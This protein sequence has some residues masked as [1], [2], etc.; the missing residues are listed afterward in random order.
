MKSYLPL[1]PSLIYG[2]VHVNMVAARTFLLGVLKSR[3]LPQHN[4]DLEFHSWLHVARKLRWP[5]GLA[6]FSSYD[7]IVTPLDIV[8]SN[9]ILAINLNNIVKILGSSDV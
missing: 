8:N 3:S 7:F 1:N 9:A 6:I 5:N 4:A 2:G